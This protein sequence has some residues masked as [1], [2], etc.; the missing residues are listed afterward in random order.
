M[1]STKTTELPRREK[2][3]LNVLYRLGEATAAQV[4]EELGDLPSYSAARALMTLLVSKGLA[5]V[6]QEPGSRQYT[7]LPATPVTKARKNAL[8][9]VMQTF[10]G[11]SPVQL[12]ANLLDPAS[13]KLSATEI[14]EL[15]ALLDAHDSTGGPTR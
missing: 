5:R 13:Q 3:A 10:F 7:Y 6:K 8:S 9:Q 12:A 2:Q 14:Q 11:N 4:M 1:P 15:R